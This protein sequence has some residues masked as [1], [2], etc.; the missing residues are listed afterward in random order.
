MH[1]KN[2]ITYYMHRAVFFAAALFAAISLFTAAELPD[3][4]FTDSVQ[5]VSLNT[6]F[7]V[8]LSENGNT[9]QAKL[10]GIFSAKTIA[11]ASPAVSEVI[12]GGDAVAVR[13]QSQG[14]LV[15]GFSDSGANPAKQAGIR[16]GDRI[17]KIGE[18]EITSNDTMAAA[19]EL[20]NGNETEITLKRGNREFT[21]SVTPRQS[22]S[23]NWQ[24]GLLVRDSTA[25]IGTLTY[26]IPETGEY[27]SLGHGITDPDTETLF[28][29]R[30]GTI[31]PAIITSVRRG[32][33]GTPGELQGL[34]SSPDL[35]SVCRN[36][37]EGLFGTLSLNLLPDREP[38]PVAQKEAVQEGD[39]VIRCTIDEG[40]I[41]EYSVRIVR[42]YRALA[43]PTKNM[44]I[45][46]T[47]PELLR[48]TGGIVQ[49]MSGSPILQ[50]GKIIGA[51][52]HVLINDP[53]RGYGIFIE[54]MLEAAA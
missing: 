9:A 18:S 16:K 25:G 37:Q 22:S 24:I 45:E 34:F 29:L 33:S 5:T 35:G 27:G 8:R 53:T 48:Q 54:N 52:T 28:P 1:H 2:G 13:L 32:E 44:L 12:P 26:V 36:T 39:A 14:V 4:I 41:R 50:D 30:Q 40:G 3:R 42:I 17:L 19:L 38:I 7:P 43:G 46:V 15:I 21:V 51:V 47:D 11:V 10:F 6:T 49:G 31:C 23:G 20:T